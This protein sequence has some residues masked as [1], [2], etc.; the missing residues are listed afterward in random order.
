[1]LAFPS[2]IAAPAREAGMKVPSDEECDDY[3]S[4]EYPHFAVYCTLH[5]GQ[6]VDW[7]TL[8]DKLTHNAKMVAAIPHDKIE[9]TTFEDLRKLGWWE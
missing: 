2:M 6:P 8:Q 9:K 5:L 4:A 1:M 3:N 7:G